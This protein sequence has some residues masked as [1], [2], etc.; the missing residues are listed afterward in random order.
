VLGLPGQSLVPC[1]ESAAW[2]PRA[3]VVPLVDTRPYALLRRGGP[4]LVVEWDGAVRPAESGDTA[5]AAP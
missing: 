2:P 1:R 5:L 4:A 3:M